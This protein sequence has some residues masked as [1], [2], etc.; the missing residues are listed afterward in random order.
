HRRNR[1]D[2]HGLPATAHLA[3][4]VAT[5]REKNH[6]TLRPPANVLLTKPLRSCGRRVDRRHLE[7]LQLRRRASLPGT[8]AHATKPQTDRCIRNRNHLDGVRR[9]SKTELHLQEQ[10]A[11][12]HGC[13]G[14]QKARPT[15]V[16][17]ATPATFQE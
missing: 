2:K 4:P 13:S 5:V 16:R 14:F 3:H 6:Q 11:P 12:W 8:Q 10:S 15:S 7:H 9:S 1:G 17:L